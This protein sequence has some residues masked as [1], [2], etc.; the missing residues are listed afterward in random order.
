MCNRKCNTNHN[1]NLNLQLNLVQG[2]AANEG[3]GGR[4]APETHYEPGCDRARRQ[5]VI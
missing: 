2:F 1:D 5:C 3:R 4:M